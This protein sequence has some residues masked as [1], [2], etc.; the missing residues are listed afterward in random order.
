MTVE[1]AR[2]TEVLP[3]RSEWQVMREMSEALHESG[4][5]PSW[6]KTPMAALAVIQKGKELG[7][8]PMY[9]LARISMIE[10]KPCCDA[11]GM[12]AM[13]YR[14][15][16]PNALT[17]VETTP[18]ACTIEYRR[19]GGRPGRLTFTIEDARRA[20]LLNKQNWKNYPQAM[21]RA[22]AISA[23]ARMAF[24]DTI[25]GLYTPEELG[26]EVSIDEHGEMTVVDVEQPDGPPRGP[27]LVD[28]P[29]AGEPTAADEAR[30]EAMASSG[31]SRVA[32]RSFA[33]EHPEHR[34]ADVR[35]Y[36]RLAALAVVR[37]HRQ[38]D[39]I[40]A[41]DAEDLTDGE[42]RGSVV[43]LQRWEA[44]LTERPAPG[45]TNADD[46]EPF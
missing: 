41:K 33:Y 25:G 42:L 1:L 30:A 18:D 4:L 11:E 27:R 34:A 16:G 12:A 46:D 23:A 19:A 2:R 36:Q 45:P 7:L 9:A 13:I 3:A 6:I 37:R 38:A 10:G 39:R 32:F 40:A 31:P 21:L 44:S 8:Q 24:P 43:N 14:D 35:E 20:G 22:R 17:F 5:L 28:D 26:A 15:H 29:D